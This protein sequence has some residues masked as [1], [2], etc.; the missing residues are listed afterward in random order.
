MSGK[1]KILVLHMKEVIYTG[2]FIFLGIIFLI[3]LAIMFLPNRTS[4]DSSSVNTEGSAETSE[5]QSS[6]SGEYTP[7]IY[8][9]TLEVSGNTLEMQVIIEQTGITDVS[10]THLDEAI[11]TMYPLFTPVLGSISEQLKNGVSLEDITYE[12]SQK[13]TANVLLSAIEQVL[14]KAAK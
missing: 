8:S 6:I 4:V 13:Y 14:E 7:G 12:D 1:T 10:F 9:A 3:L 2:I 11:E 5:N